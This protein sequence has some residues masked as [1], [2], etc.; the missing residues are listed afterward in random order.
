MSLD[1]I[2]RFID[3]TKAYKRLF[4]FYPK[5]RVSWHV[6]GYGKSFLSKVP[7]IAILLYDVFGLYNVF[8]IIFIL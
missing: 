6:S 2:R 3:R 1:G 8:D 7:I 4:W 5:W